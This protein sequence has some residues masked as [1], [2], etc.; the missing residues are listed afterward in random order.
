[1]LHR[2][3]FFRKTLFQKNLGIFDQ[4]FGHQ[5]AENEARNTKMNRG[6]ETRPLRVNARYVMNGTNS[7]CFFYSRN[8]IFSQIFGHQRAENEARNTKM[9]R[10]QETHPIRINARYEMNWANSF[11]NK[12]RKPCL[13]TDGQ[14]SGWIQYTPIPPSV[15][16][17]YNNVPQM[18]IYQPTHLRCTF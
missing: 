15:E 3:E 14:T 6:Q 17:G 2:W 18:N 7:C 13:Q 10:G 5:R 1:M 12:F 4:I 16:R 9:Y 8:P 11:F